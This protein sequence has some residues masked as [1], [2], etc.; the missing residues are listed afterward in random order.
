MSYSAHAISWC[1][2]VSIIISCETIYP[3]AAQQPTHQPPTATEV[4][5]LRSTCAD[6]GEQIL[7]ASG[8][9]IALGISQVSHYEPRTNRCYVE[10]IIQPA[11]ITPGGQYFVRSLYDGQTR[12]MLAY[13][14]QEKGKWEGMV[15][16]RQHQSTGWD[17]ANAYINKMMADDRK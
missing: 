12:E 14:K 13:A 16:D 1:F 17:E 6:L 2:V 15:F 11:Y 5:N 4:F 7:E 10:I 9:E 3:A 8:G